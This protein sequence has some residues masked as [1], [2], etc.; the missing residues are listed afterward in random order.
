MD[1]H[2]KNILESGN[3]EHLGGYS[4]QN[5]RLLRVWKH[6]QTLWIFTKRHHTSRNLEHEQVL[7][8]IHTKHQTYWS[9]ETGTKL[10]DHAEILISSRPR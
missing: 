10:H 3:H 4:H 6:E 8:D 7:A 1:I 5:I 9:L 2:K